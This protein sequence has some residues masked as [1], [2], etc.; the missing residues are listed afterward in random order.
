MVQ[1]IYTDSKHNNPLCR[2]TPIE[3]MNS[4]TQYDKEKYKQ[5]ILD[6]AEIV[7]GFFGF[8]RTVYSNLKRNNGKRKKWYE[9]LKNK[10]KEIFKLKC[11]DPSH[12]ESK[13][14]IA[15][16]VI[17]YFASN[18]CNTI[19]AALDGVIQLGKVHSILQI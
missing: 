8:D 2:V 17:M 19:L 16:T 11:F 13:I 15:M 5:M 9:D 10:R 18:S 1:Y 14:L 12:L 3:N 4:I 7:L 6:A